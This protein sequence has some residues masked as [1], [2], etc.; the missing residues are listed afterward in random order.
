MWWERR[1]VVGE[2]GCGG[3]GVVWWGGGY[4]MG[5]EGCGGRIEGVVNLYRH[6]FLSEGKYDIKILCSNYSHDIRMNK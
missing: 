2:E 1:D 3:R 5:E 6:G 4:A